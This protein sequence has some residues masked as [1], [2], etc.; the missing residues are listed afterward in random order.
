MNPAQAMAAAAVAESTLDSIGGPKG[1]LGRVVGLGTDELDAG[2]PGWAW[3]GIG[4]MVGGMLT[5][6]LRDKIERVVEG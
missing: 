6:A 3:L 2:V 5:Y 4:V 1:F